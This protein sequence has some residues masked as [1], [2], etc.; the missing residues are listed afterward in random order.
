VSNPPADRW[1]IDGVDT[2]VAVAAIGGA[3]L[4][5]ALVPIDIKAAALGAA[6][7]TFAAVLASVQGTLEEK[8]LLAAIV[9][10][11]TT[12]LP[13]RVHVGPV[14]G[15][16]AATIAFAA[17]IVPFLL[18][19]PR[20]IS[21]LPWSS[22]VLLVWIFVVCI[23]YWPMS[24]IGA[25]NVLVVA[26]FLAFL[27]MSRHLTESEGSSFRDRV[28]KALTVAGWSAVVLYGLSV[29]TGGLGS[30][31]VMGARAFALFA[32]V[33]FAWAIARFRYERRSGLLAAMLFILILLGL[34]RGALGAAT[35]VVGLTWLDGRSLGA[36]LK[37]IALAFMAVGI[38][39]LAVANVPALHN[40]FFSGDVQN[41]GHG[42]AINVT[43]RE[44][45]WRP[46][47]ADYLKSPWIGR[48]A[49]SGDSLIGRLT[50]GRTGN[51]HNDYL[52]VL[53]DYGVIGL[54]LWVV[55]LVALLYRL[56]KREYRGD[57]AE[58]W[59]RGAYLA[60]V[61]V[62]I[63]MA[64]DNPL[65]EIDVMAPLAII[66]GV[67]FGTHST[68]SAFAVTRIPPG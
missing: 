10:S 29:V 30:D 67:A 50:A 23:I 26:L 47:W 8:L 32:L 25:Q 27:A 41:V 3:L 11:A 53:H 22:R 7:V 64:V 19:R 28:D 31:T 46:V 2:G 9:L 56:R 58:R 17:A 24:V 4:V 42:V 54:S 59:R 38:S 16:G 6:T 65:I 61:A 49:G 14:S 35:V 44:S 51:V 68:L 15:L 62:G 36:W 34:S 52:R 1:P 40:R 66:I 57:V 60:L 18:L 37:G 48:G 45:V 39:V 55:V 20:T 13:L 63:E 12:D 43:G 21:F 33:A 5:G